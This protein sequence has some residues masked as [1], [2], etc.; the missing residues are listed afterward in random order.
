MASL[1]VMPSLIYGGTTEDHLGSLVWNRMNVPNHSFIVSLAIQQRLLT[2]DRLIKFG[3]ITES[4]CDMF[5][6]QQEDNYH[7]LY[8]CPF[9]AQCWGLFKNWVNINMPLVGVL[10]WGLKWRYRSLLKK[11]M[12]LAAMVAMVYHI[13]NVRNKCRIEFMIPRPC[14]VLAEVQTTARLHTIVVK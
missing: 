2:K 5:L 10:E 8:D 14:M 4:L 12:V 1:C 11:Q 7:L 9:S 3:I 13:W 6:A